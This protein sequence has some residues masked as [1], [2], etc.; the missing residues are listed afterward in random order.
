MLEIVHPVARRE[1]LLMNSIRSPAAVVATSHRWQIEVVD[2]LIYMNT[3]IDL[4]ALQ[5]AVTTASITTN[6]A[7]END[8]LHDWLFGLWTTGNQEQHKRQDNGPCPCPPA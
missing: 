5:A 8:I 3:S 1:F 7:E 2:L 4:K 6:T